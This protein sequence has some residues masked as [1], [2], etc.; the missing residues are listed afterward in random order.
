M[1]GSTVFVAEWRDQ[2]GR[3][4]P[5]PEREYYADTDCGDFFREAV[6]AYCDGKQV[7]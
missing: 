4:S 5:V 2:P 7:E 3:F 6:A 1:G